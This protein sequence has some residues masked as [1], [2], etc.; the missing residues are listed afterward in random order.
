MDEKKYEVLPT[1]ADIGIIAYGEDLVSLFKNTAEGM[2][3]LI[4]EMDNVEAKIDESVEVS[5]PNLFD[6]RGFLAKEFDIKELSDKNL[7]AAVKGET[8]NLE[9]HAIKTG[10][11]GA[12]YHK[13]EVKKID[14][15]WKAQVIFDV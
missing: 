6:A 12:T 15:L 4:A 11:K 14:H 7:K 2:F 13:L 9:K 3:D 10:I 8:L 1:T 5:A